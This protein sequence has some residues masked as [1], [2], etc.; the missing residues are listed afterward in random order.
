MQQ[1]KVEQ[2]FD[3]MK[4]KKNC[5]GNGITVVVF[6][7][8]LALFSQN[9]EA[10]DRTLSNGFS[11]QLNLGS[12]SSGFGNPG[13]ELEGLDYGILYGLQIGNRWYFSP[14]ETWGVGLMINWFDFTSSRGSDEV[15]SL[16]ASLIELGP[17]GTY[18]INQDMA[19]DGYYNLRPTFLMVADFDGFGFGGFGVTHTLGV[20]YRWKVISVGIEKVFGGVNSVYIDEDDVYGDIS[21]KLK[22]N[23]TRFVLGFKF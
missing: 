6:G 23:S 20:A 17:I 7:I 2:T 16:D 8:I 9:L 18:V 12:A 3:D 22:N 11:L 14:T 13:D 19:I 10:K 4:N 5:T 1:P 21:Y 15:V